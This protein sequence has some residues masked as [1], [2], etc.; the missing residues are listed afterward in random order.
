MALT[1]ARRGDQ[2][3]ALQHLEWVCRHRVRPN[4]LAE[5]NHRDHGEPVSALPLGWAHA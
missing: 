3:A 5:Q 4:L 1:Q 2:A